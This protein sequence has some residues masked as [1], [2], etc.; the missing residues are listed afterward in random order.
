MIELEILLADQRLFSTAC[1]AA[2][3]LSA[4]SAQKLEGMVAPER[5][6]QFLLGRWLLARAS[7]CSPQEIEESAA[8]FPVITHRPDIHASLSHSGP[9]VGVVVSTGFRCGL[10]IEY[11][12]RERDWLAL[13]ERAFHPDERAWVAAAPDAIV[14]RFH[15]IWTLREAAFKAGLRD[16]VV[17]GPQAF[18]PVRLQAMQ[19]ICWHY[20]QQ[21]GFHISLVAR[22]PFTSCLRFLDPERNPRR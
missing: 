15:T 18:D 5:R 21:Q 17:A 9:Y 22:E 14:E 4:S 16:E 1:L 6:Q 10:D 13:A 19:R 11:P 2:Q 8:G 20:Q 3:P 12:A 7:G